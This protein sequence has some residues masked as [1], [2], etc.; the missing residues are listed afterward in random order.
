MN[1]LL[2]LRFVIGL[3]FLATGG[4]LTA[5]YFFSDKNLMENPSVNLWCGI[6]FFCFGAFMV[7]ISRTNKINDQ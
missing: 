1:K 5:Y 4:L 7:I 3:F 6:A 2:D